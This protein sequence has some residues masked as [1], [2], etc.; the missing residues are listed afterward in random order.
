VKGWTLVGLALLTVAC[1]TGERRVATA[2][3]TAQAEVPGFVFATDT[4]TFPNQVRAR[5]PPS[6]YLYANYCFVM[7]R[8][9]RQFFLFARFEPTAPRLT[10]DAYVERV[11]AVVARRPWEPPLPP[12]D[13]IVIPG[14]A[15]LREFSAA[16]EAAVKA[17]LGGRFWTFVH[18]TNWRVAFPVPAAQQER[19]ARE[20]IAELEAGRLVQLLVTN[21]PKIELNHT[22]VAFGYR[23]TTRGVEFAIWDPNEPEAPGV[24]LFDQERRRFWAERMFDTEPGVIRA[25][26]MYHSWF[27]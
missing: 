17:G 25:F 24:V 14:Y 21:I 3:L 26:R 15:D 2:D 11:R 6:E 23:Q 1:A 5:T 12:D 27:W 10:H 16:E 7:A 9:L 8:A 20:T 19:V 18:W 22:V 4:F 13:R